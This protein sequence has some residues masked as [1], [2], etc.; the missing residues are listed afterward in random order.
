MSTTHSTTN[1]ILQTTSTRIFLAVAVC[2]LLYAFFFIDYTPLQ[3]MRIVLDDT[4]TT[5]TTAAM[6]AV[7]PEVSEEPIPVISEKND[8]APISAEELEP[9]T[10]E[11]YI[12]KYASVAVTEMHKYGIPASISMG[13]ALIES[14][15]GQSLLAKKCRNH[16][17]L[18]CWSKKHRGCCMKFKDDNNNDSF[19]HFEKSA[20]ESWRAHSKLLSQGRYLELQKHGKD[21]RAWA[22]GLKAIGYATDPNY[23]AKL[24]GII[25][26]Y[27]LHQ[28]DRQ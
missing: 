26:R 13:Q 18:K 20:W 1:S 27:D 6:S 24:I 10:T 25:E 2:V 19:R 16:F 21:Y 8:Q 23:A 28:L 11:E 22:R 17:G 15:A 5:N 7:Q 12:D 4:T 14:R 9:Q 3:R